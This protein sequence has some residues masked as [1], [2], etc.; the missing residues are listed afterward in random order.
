MSINPVMLKGD[1]GWC[2]CDVEKTKCPQVVAH[3]VQSNGSHLNS[4]LQ[5][6]VGT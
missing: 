6:T 4:I 2:Q 1:C 5:S 3:N